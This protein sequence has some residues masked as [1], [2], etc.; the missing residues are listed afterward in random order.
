M[1]YLSR[2]LA[3]VGI[4]SLIAIAAAPRT[5][6][7]SEAPDVDRIVE[8]SIVRLFAAADNYSRADRPAEAIACYTAILAIDPSRADARAGLFRATE[9]LNGVMVL[10][11]GRVNDALPPR[12]DNNP[13]E[14]AVAPPED[15]N[16]PLTDFE[17]LDRTV[18]DLLRRQADFIQRIAALERTNN[19]PG[20]LPPIEG[21]LER[22]V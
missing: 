7:Q 15:D 16:V 14:Q 5:A 10:P 19:P 17:R 1:R 20:A 2:A 4:I 11:G 22:R 3:F 12:P 18:S 13:G 21:P 8:N 6:G 9:T